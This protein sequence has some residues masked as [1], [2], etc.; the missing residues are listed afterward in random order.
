MT[1]IVIYRI[2]NGVVQ[3]FKSE[4]TDYQEIYE[5]PDEIIAENYVNLPGSLCSDLVESGQL[6]Y[7]IINLDI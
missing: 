2:N 3:A 7:E 6:S 4:E 5:F 1:C